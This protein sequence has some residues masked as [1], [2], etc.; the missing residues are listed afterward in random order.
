MKNRFFVVL[1]AFVTLFSKTARA[2][3]EFDA[4]G[5]AKFA[6]GYSHREKEYKK[7][8]K[9]N[10]FP[11]DFWLSL[12]AS[13]VFLQD[14]ELSLFADFMGGTDKY[15]KDYNQGSW[16]EEVY[17]KL[18][19]PYGQFD[20]GQ[21]NNV[22]YSQGVSAPA[23][24]LLSANNSD[25]VDFI[26]NPNW[27]QR[28]KTT[29]FKTLNSTY[30][31]T[32]GDAPKISYI[33]P[34]FFGTS[35]GVSYVPYAYSKSGLVNKHASYHNNGG[36]IFSAHGS[37]D[38]EYA[39][40]EASLGYAE[41]FENDKEYSAGLSLYRKGFTL[42]ASYRRT[43]ENGKKN[44]ERKNF[45]LPDFFDAYRNS[46]AYAIGLGYEIGPF[47]TAVTYFCSQAKKLDF[48]D[49]ILQFSNEFQL[50]KNASFY[51]AIAHVNFSGEKNVATTNNK[52]YAF[53][54][55]TAIKF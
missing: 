19:S 28:K 33:S 12:S 55:G 17:L 42:G 14:Y 50:N 35:L 46:E 26:H 40:M 24:G 44:E 48:K 10:I 13:E 2:E 18:K 27:I 49:K 47:K 29:S 39:E 34:E 45:K 5:E 21:I 3:A 54:I 6:Y 8:Q 37:Y 32:D 1:L 22:A 41:F 36:L 38:L 15:L 11:T 51:G 20:I 7:N 9:N 52:G 31:N 43:N 16:G 25:I 4:Q 30:I 53:V 23:F